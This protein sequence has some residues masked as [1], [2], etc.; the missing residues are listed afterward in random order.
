MIEPH[1]FLQ[2]SQ[3]DHWAKAMNEKLEKIEKNKTWYIIP[4]LNHKNVI[5]TKW[6]YR[7]N[8]NK[9]GY[10]VRKKARMVCKWYAQVEGM[11]IEETFSL[12]ARIEETRMILEF[13]CYKK[14][15]F[16]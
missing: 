3:D 10:I 16:Y 13:A 2:A 12:F 6:L 8:L 9:K 1:N 4:R 11:D 7:N 14:F 5:G 15:K